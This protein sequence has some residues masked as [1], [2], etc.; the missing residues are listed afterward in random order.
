MTWQQQ[1]WRKSEASEHLKRHEWAA[2]FAKICFHG[3]IENRHKKLPKDT[4]PYM[5]QDSA[6]L[7]KPP[8]HQY[9]A[10]I[11][12]KTHTRSVSHIRILRLSSP[13]SQQA[14]SGYAKSGMENARM[15]SLSS[16]SPAARSLMHGKKSTFGTSLSGMRFSGMPHRS[17]WNLAFL[18][19]WRSFR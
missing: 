17:G 13:D 19:I 8:H 4:L 9:S 6:P 16:T 7:F 15:G 2:T 14:S 11:F 3:L 1:H 5:P 12:P 18:I 10:H